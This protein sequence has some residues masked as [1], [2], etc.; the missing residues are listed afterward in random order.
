MKKA[1]LKGIVFGITFFLAIVI[2]SKIMNKGNNDLTAEMPAAGLP[3]I[4]MGTEGMVYNELH[5]YVTLMDTA[6]MRDTITALD[7]KR[8][9]EFTMDTYGE[10][11]TEISYEVRS[12]DGER[13]V[14]NTQVKDYAVDGD[15]V[16]GTVTIKDLI[17]RNIEYELIF[18]VSTERYNNIRYYTRVVYP[19]DYYLPEKLTFAKEFTEKTFDKE[20]AQDLA[21]YMETN[22]EG[23]NS[24]L[25]EV[26]IHCSLSQVSWGKL[27][28]AP[29]TEPVFNVTELAKQTASL[30]AH[31]VVSAGE[32]ED[33]K[34]FYIEEYYRV[35]YTAERMYLLDYRR[36]MNSIVDEKDDIYVNDKIIIG[37]ES[38]KLPLVESE[39]GNVFAFEVQNKLYC[40]NVTTNKLTVVFGFYDS[41]NAD[42]RTL[43]NQHTVKALDIDEGG[44]I[45]FAVYGYMNRGRH[46]G[47]VGIQIYQYNSALN[48]IEEVIY[49]PYDKPYQVLKAEME[50]LLYLNR[51]G[52]LYLMLDS[53]VY[54]ISLSEK[55][56]SRLVEAVADDGLKVSDSHQMI[57]WQRGGLYES[58]ELVLMNLATRDRISIKANADE[59]I[60]PLDFMGEDFIYGMARQ[61]DILV[62]STGKVTFPMYAVCI[63]S[64]G[65]QILKTYR[66]EEIYITE[67]VL[68]NNQISLSRL[69][70]NEDGSYKETTP[71]YIMNSSEVVTGKNTIK[72][73]VTENYGRYVQI[74]VRKEIDAKTIQ[75]LTPKEVLFEG[76]RKLVLEAENPPRR[77]YV[78]GLGGVAGIYKEPAS[79]IMLAE[80]QS[81]IVMN[82]AGDYVWMKGN[83]AV[84]NQIMAIEG[85][86]ETEEESS[87]AVCLGVMLKYEGIIR[88]TEYLLAQGQNAYSILEENLEDVQI[89]NLEGCSLD[90]TLYYVNQDIPVLAIL[91]DGSAVLVVGFNEYNVVLMN[92]QNGEV[93]KMGKNDAAEWFAQNGNCFITYIRQNDN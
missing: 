68:Q 29:V 35:R 63:R 69:I 85:V 77:Y 19:E 8:S 20:A 21:I 93:K 71:D 84:R 81:G 26:D 15:I 80:A 42:A 23:D 64:T 10:A 13:L 86:K 39:D 3:V 31:Y 89:L 12:L 7:E 70:K 88:N 38:D 27:Q 91:K 37:V 49:I 22:A 11:V 72:E 54:E 57:V 14:E 55:S 75:I 73:V 36:V 30:T 58:G 52:Y 17:E 60:M 47:E 92:P 5:G 83:R 18:I 45:R 32:G 87:L 53:V 25:H 76:G 41:N 82:A 24:T 61:E 66:Q 50:Q 34:Y 28:I 56:Y 43:Y 59:Y 33:I 9:T 40:Y 1:I 74:A 16:T 67:C 4:Y 2:I 46:E 62:D 78:Y 6:F 48:T 90:S 44:N 79:A 51:E 65:G